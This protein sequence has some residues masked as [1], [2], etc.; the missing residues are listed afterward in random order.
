MLKNTILTIILTVSVLFSPGCGGKNKSTTLPLQITDSRDYLTEILKASK[1]DPYFSGKAKIKINSPGNN[2]TAKTI[3]FVKSPASL[4]VEMLNFFNQ[5]YLFLVTNKKNLQM[6]IPS[7]NKIYFDKASPENLS[8]IIGMPIEISDFIS[9]IA[10]RPPSFSLRK[11][12]ITLT[13][14][15]DYLIFKIIKKPETEEIWVD[16][17]I[18][19][20]IKYISYKDGLPQMEIKYSSFKQFSNRLLPSLIELFLPANNCGLLIDFS[21]QEFNA[22]PDDL[23]KLTIPNNASVLPF[24]A[25]PAP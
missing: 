1:E 4:H 24:S 10:C 21:S 7:E 8:R 18:N 3:F 2:F 11:S 15:N 16:K 25:I 19:R 23:F 12:K 14:K 6:Y 22:F 17:K 20:I 5:P 9:I 13:E